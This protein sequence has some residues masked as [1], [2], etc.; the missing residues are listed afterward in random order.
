MT[1]FNFKDTQHW[2]SQLTRFK[3]YVSDRVAYEY[4]ERH[5]LLALIDQL[6]GYVA[7]GGKS[8]IKELKTP[9]TGSEIYE[10]LENAPEP[11][12][13]CNT[14]LHIVYGNHVAMDLLGL[15]KLSS[16]QRRYLLSFLVKNVAEFLNWVAGNC[17][18]SVVQEISTV[19][20]NVTFEV[21]KQRIRTQGETLFILSLHVAT[22]AMDTSIRQWEQWYRKAFNHAR[23]AMFILNADQEFI[24]VN[25]RFCEI[26]GYSEPEVLG[27]SPELLK[28]GYHDDQFYQEFYETLID[29]GYW[30]GIVYNQAKSGHIYPQDLKAVALFLQ[31]ESEQPDG[32]I[33]VFDN[34]E[35]QVR[36]ELDL[37]DASETDP[38]TGLMNRNGFNHVISDLFRDAE[39]SGHTLTLIYIDMDRFKLLN[40]THGHS[41]GDE[42]L[43]VLASRLRHIMKPDDVLARL[44]GDEFVVLLEGE[45]SETML[46]S[47]LNKL[48]RHLGDPYRIFDTLHESSASLGVARYPHDALTIDGLIQAG[49]AAMYQAKKNGRGCYQVFDQS[50]FAQETAQ[51][52]L[53]NKINTGFIRDEFIPY[54]QPQFDLVSKEVVGF[55]SLCRWLTPEGKMIAPG[56]F[57]P[58][59]EKDKGMMTKLG[60]SMAR[61]VFRTVDILIRHNFRLP[62]ALN[63]SGTQLASPRVIEHLIFMSESHPDAAKLIEIEITETTL[64]EGD[65]A[66]LDH[67]HQ[68]QE[69]GFEFVLDDF[70][71]GFSSIYSLKQIRFKKIKI[72]RSFVMDIGD[73]HNTNLLDGM[74]GLIQQLELEIICEGIETE[75]QLNYLIAKGCATGQG[76]YYSPAVSATEAAKMLKLNISDV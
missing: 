31:E 32:F 42:M 51:E 70:G 18:Q 45:F 25:H 26:T 49:D 21:S 5:E 68:L 55:E 76:F 34:I 46:D 57:L 35:D 61:H 40:D 37:K 62:V 11:L 60:M 48:L 39:R 13:V 67:I 19:D 23:E 73:R 1:D 66:I 65:P 24:A 2:L 56:G 10:Y 69:I 28:S 16:P 22:K 3:S 54:F 74:I 27:R 17:T 7:D 30:E 14:K 4:E 36:H 8:A 50:I 38:L 71:T 75:E 58:E 72:D 63:L 9:E 64:F 43:R 12:I 44:G 41:Y 15:N 6:E 29:T 59:M 33:G 20:G 52:E 47:I 53:I